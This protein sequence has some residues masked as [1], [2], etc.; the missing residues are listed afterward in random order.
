MTATVSTA[1]AKGSVLNFGLG[2]AEIA[3]IVARLIAEGKAIQDNVAAQADP[4]FDN[5]IAQLA[6]RESEQ[7]AEYGLVT[8]LQ[9][10]S[11]DKDVRDASMAAEEKL[12]AFEIES[13]MREDVY[14]VVR[15]V[16]DNAD[17]MA[18]LGPEDRR[19]VEKLELDYRRNGLALGKAE[20]ERLGGI[21]KRL[22]ELSIL[23]SRNV[24]EGDGHEAFTRE[25]LA[26]LPDDYFE[27]R[28]TTV[29][30]GVEKYAV[31]TKYPD[32]IPA[33]KLA[34]REDTR[35]RLLYAEETRCPD[36]IPILQEAVRLRLEAARLLGYKTHAE[37]VLEVNMAK[38]PDAVL[39]FEHDLRARL[40]VLS[41]REVREL[42]PLKR[43]DKEAAGEPYE[44]LF[45]WDFR[46]YANLVKERKH[47]VSDEVTKQYFPM[48]EVTRG[49]LDMY[50]EMLGLRFVRVDS[51]PV[52]HADVEMYEVWEAEGDAFV[53]HFYLDLYPR[54]NKYN[55][56]AVWPIRPG[57]VRA[58]GSRE[59]PVA[60]MVAN[61]PKPTQSAPAL[62]KHSDA[63]TLL[64]ELGHVF[65]G[66]CSVT[67]WGR[68]HGTNVEG[69]FVEAPSQMLENWGWE[70]A[71][72]RRFAVHH[73]TG[74][75]IPEDLVERLVAAKNEGSGMFNLRQVFFGLYDLA[76]HNTED[77][78][79]DV[80]E[81]YRRLREEICNFKNDSA[82]TWGAATF[83]HLLGGY[84]GQYAGYM[85]SEVF[86]ADMYESRFK[87]DGVTN[88]LTGLDYRREILRPGGS[89]DAMVSLERFLGRKPNNKAF[90]HSI[91]LDAE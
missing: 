18:R 47:N 60:A 63:V 39:E 28:P 62:L 1:P 19:L 24:N 75:P 17:E 14:K 61:F 21:R 23:F 65:H 25:E 78:D 7:S 55:H 81:A 30:D 40:S 3:S 76:L 13:R 44:G 34:Q 26:G 45:I 57:F 67:K 59:Y 27:G 80:K 9:N 68:F 33:M 4:T 29:V 90:L 31:T 42:E 53:G 74:E 49:I 48:K 54:E 22:S 70:P 16:F 46:Y 35:R 8:F 79:V 43:A 83:G 15:A 72:L 20:R 38:H 86:S 41:D 84:D 85:W 66:I 50:Q 37:F 36:N 6:M 56:A 32:L 12:N 11:T 69:D 64:H 77:G 10:V 89:R 87:R 58:D 73:R 71:V 82:D 91:G 51:P 5:V 2:P 88:P 52:W